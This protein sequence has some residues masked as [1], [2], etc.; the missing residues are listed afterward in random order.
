MVLCD[1]PCSGSGTWRRT[2]EAKWRLTPDRLADLTR[3]QSDILRQAAC[4]VA[5]GGCLAYMTCSVLEVENRAVIDHFCETHPAWS[6]TD[7]RHWPVSP[8]GDGFFL[9]QFRGPATG[10]DHG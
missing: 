2:P 9:A 10:M 1:V 8:T 6:V 5:P 7:M 3:I 4:L